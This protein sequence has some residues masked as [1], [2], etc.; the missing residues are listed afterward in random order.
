MVM[1]NV[2][3][4]DHG[5]VTRSK[6]CAADALIVDPPVQG[7][8]DWAKSR[9]L[10][11]VY[12][13]PLSVKCRNYDPPLCPPLISIWTI[14]SSSVTNHQSYQDLRSNVI[15]EN[16]L[17][18]RNFTFHLER[19]SSP[20]TPVYDCPITMANTPVLSMP[21]DPR[22][23][24]ILDELLLIRADLDLLKQDRSTYIKSSTVVPLYDRVVDQVTKLSAVR[25]GRPNV[26]NK[27]MLQHWITYVCL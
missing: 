17:V 4:A 19:T 11:P 10:G 20:S 26:Q 9:T 24:P 12:A 16:T 1:R 8:A 13:Y 25:E 15:P 18:S 21:L 3:D 5:F 27:G 23:Q 14:S 6:I 22:E 7:Q 2:F